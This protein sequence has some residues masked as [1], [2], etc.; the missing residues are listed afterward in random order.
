MFI[1]GCQWLEIEENCE[2]FAASTKR[3]FL[4]FDV[5][6]KAAALT[7]AEKELIDTHSEK[8]AKIISLV[9]AVLQEAVPI[10]SAHHKYYF[11]SKKPSSEEKEVAPLGAAIIAVADAYDAMI[12]DRPYRAGRPPGFCSNLS[13]AFSFMFFLK[14]SIYGQ[15]W[16][17]FLY[18]ECRLLLAKGGLMKILGEDSLQP[19]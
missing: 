14:F 16:A 8:G 15:F 1:P 10:V 13:F 5:L 9:G 18:T 17:K 4:S 12:T 3:K 2:R 7:T 11:E 6:H 19:A